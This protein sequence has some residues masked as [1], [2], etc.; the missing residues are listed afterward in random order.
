MSEQK[1]E[2]SSVE[3][4]GNS[5]VLVP[6]HACLVLLA[7]AIHMV[8]MALSTSPACCM[9]FEGALVRLSLPEA[10][11]PCQC[12]RHCVSTG[13]LL[14]EGCARLVSCLS[15]EN[16]RRSEECWYPSSPADITH[17]WM[18]RVE[19]WGLARVARA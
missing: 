15:A 6:L 13:E 14:P 18:V 2:E 1:S 5:L 9:R 3:S 17:S 12:L 4:N 10:S 16:A 7:A 8:W 19:R 11:G